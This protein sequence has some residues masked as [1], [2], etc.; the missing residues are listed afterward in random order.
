MT[1]AMA[2]PRLGHSIVKWGAIVAIAFFARQSIQV[3]AGKTT[4]ANI[5][6][7]IS[8]LG[9]EQWAL[10]LSW[11]LTVIVSVAFLIATRIYR[12]NLAEKA[13]RITELE[14]HF[15]HRRSS[16][17]LARDGSTREEDK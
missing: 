2:W 11:A 9:R 12:N 1:K 4:L 10:T 3:I 8:V 17:R 16:S 13:K 6:V 14:R 7:D 15:D 5:L